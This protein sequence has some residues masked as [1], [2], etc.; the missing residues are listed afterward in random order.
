M[1][2]Q[3]LVREVIIR[4]VRETEM[5]DWI[6]FSGSAWVSETFRIPENVRDSRPDPRFGNFRDLAH[7]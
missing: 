3:I 5:L 7:L 2:V 4:D 1:K 6:G